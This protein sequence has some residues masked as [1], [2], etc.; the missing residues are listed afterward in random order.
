MPHYQAPMG[1]GSL[2]RTNNLRSTKVLSIN[3]T[4][5]HPHVRQQLPVKKSLLITAFLLLWVQEDTVPW[6]NMDVFN[7]TLQPSLQRTQVGCESLRKPDFKM[8]YI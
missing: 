1:A 3:K 5:P 8:S 2:P 6:T 4:V 7:R